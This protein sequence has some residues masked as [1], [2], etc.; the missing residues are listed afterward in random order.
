MVIIESEERVYDLF[1]Q[2]MERVNGHCLFTTSEMF[3]YIYGDVIEK[4]G[5]IALIQP[6]NNVNVIK[7]RSGDRGV[8]PLAKFNEILR[9][10]LNIK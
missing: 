2:M 7:N 5:I 10:Y 3:V 6:D 9:D 1:K 8:V 4:A